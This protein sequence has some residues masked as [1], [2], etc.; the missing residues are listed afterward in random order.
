MCKVLRATAP[1]T[2]FETLE[3]FIVATFL[4]ELSGITGLIHAYSRIFEKK[5][6]RPHISHLQTVIE[7]RRA[8]TN[9]RKPG[10]DKEVS[11]A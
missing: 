7:R 3:T 1:S 5:E 2:A 6:T 10:E 8:K 9:F 11:T 4:R